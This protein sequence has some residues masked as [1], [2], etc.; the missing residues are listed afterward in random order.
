MHFRKW[1][2][3]QSKWVKLKTG[4]SVTQQKQTHVEPMSETVGNFFFFLFFFSQKRN[5]LEKSS[6]EVTNMSGYLLHSIVFQT[7]ILEYSCCSSVWQVFFHLIV[8][9]TLK[10]QTTALEGLPAIICLMQTGILWWNGE[11]VFFIN[12]INGFTKTFSADANTSRCLP[13]LTPLLI[14]DGRP[15][16]HYKFL[17]LP[18]LSLPSKSKMAANIFVKSILSTRS[19]KLCLFCRLSKTLVFGR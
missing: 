2:S 19:P 18:C 1:A 7:T 16:P 13:H 9:N 6:P 10:Q 11:A 12:K 5:G 17:S 3:N 15:P 8:N 4:S 14:F